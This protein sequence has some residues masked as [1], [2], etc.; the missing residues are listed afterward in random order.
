MISPHLQSEHRRT[1]EIA[2]IIGEV[3][4]FDNG[5]ADGNLQLQGEL[6]SRSGKK[7]VRMMKIS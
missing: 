1:F 2:P 3:Q 6:R 7:C 5:H 4:A